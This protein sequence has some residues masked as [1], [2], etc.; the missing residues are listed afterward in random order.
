MTPAGHV[1]TWVV[2][3]GG[4]AGRCECGAVR[5]FAGEVPVRLLLRGACLPRQTVDERVR[6]GGHLVTTRRRIKGRTL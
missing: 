1:H 6:P 5:A 4:G 3:P 2:P